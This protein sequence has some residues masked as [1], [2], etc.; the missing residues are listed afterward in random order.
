M[1]FSNGLEVWVEEVQKANNLYVRINSNTKRNNEFQQA[2]NAIYY[3][4]LS[5]DKAI[6]ESLSKIY[7][8]LK[9]ESGIALYSYGKLLQ[10][11]MK[12]KHSMQTKPFNE[13]IDKC[14]PLMKE[15][16]DNKVSQNE[17]EQY[18]TFM[19][20]AHFDEDYDGLIAEYNKHKDEMAQKIKERQSEKITIDYTH[21]RFDEFEQSLIAI[22][23]KSYT[24]HCFLRKLD[25]KK[26]LALLGEC[27]VEEIEI[28]RGELQQVYHIG[29]VMNDKQDLQQLCKGIKDDILKKELQSAQRLQFRWFL[30]KMDEYLSWLDQQQTY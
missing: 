10:C 24:D 21:D 4:S 28:I 15:N 27:S 25:I 20:E 1:L 14:V 11:L 30:E 26:F 8:L 2:F 22:K 29:N 6:L 7:Q 9:S 13:I 23:N 16:I 19:W 18:S 17:I 5:S 3:Y 12:V